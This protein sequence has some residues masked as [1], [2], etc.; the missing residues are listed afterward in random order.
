[1]KKLALFTAAMVLCAGMALA[2]SPVKKAPATAAKPA[3]SQV[4]NS[5]KQAPQSATKQTPKDEAKKE[6]C[7]KCPNHGQCQKNS[8]SAKPACNGNAA[9]QKPTKADAGVA[10]DN[11]GPK[12]EGKQ[13]R[14][15]KK[16]AG[17]ANN[18]SVTK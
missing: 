16:V 7:G 2:Q 4:D 9:V 12:K 10:K 15:Q 3:A 14:D 11:N 6:G 17:N 18:S 13:N 8:Q 1:M 5:K